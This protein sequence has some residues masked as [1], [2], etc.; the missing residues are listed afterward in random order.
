MGLKVDKTV[1]CYEC[2]DRLIGCHASCERYKAFKENDL[3]KWKQK[4]SYLQKENHCYFK[5]SRN[6]CCKLRDRS[7]GIAKGTIRFN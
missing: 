3:K 6:R 4:V 2:P 5:I 1:P 7:K